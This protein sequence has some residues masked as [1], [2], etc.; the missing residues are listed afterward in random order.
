MG[1]QGRNKNKRETENERVKNPEKKNKYTKMPF[2]NV[3]NSFSFR[4]PINKKK[5][6]KTKQ[7]L[8]NSPK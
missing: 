2:F 7:T 5:K 3:K 4:N 1:K 6:N 8:P